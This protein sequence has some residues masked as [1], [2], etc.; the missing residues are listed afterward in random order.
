MLNRGVVVAVV[1]VVDVIEV[2]A[3]LVAVVVGDVV[4]V[5]VTVVVGVVREQPLKPPF[6]KSTSIPFTECRLLLHSETS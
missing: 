4:V 5:E 6:W 2:V 1:V 3:V